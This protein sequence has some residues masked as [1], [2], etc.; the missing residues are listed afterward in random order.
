VPPYTCAYL[1]R[2]SAWTRTTNGYQYPVNWSTDFQTVTLIK[3]GLL[4][5]PVPLPGPPL[6][7]ATG[8]EK[9]PEPGTTVLMPVKAAAQ[10]KS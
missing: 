3:P 7:T 5:R 8:F 10:V 6:L 2:I 1:F 9:L 4:L